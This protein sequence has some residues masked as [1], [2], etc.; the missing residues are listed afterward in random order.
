MESNLQDLY[1]QAKNHK[2]NHKSC[3]GEPYKSFEKL[4]EIVNQFKTEIKI[5][6]VG[7]AVGF[8]T[9]ILQNKINTIDTIELHQEHIDE[10]KV[11]II[12]WG[13]DI[14]KANFL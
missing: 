11:N 3:G 5:L 10:A 8:T 9:F 12:G 2:D 1:N 14:N 13:G 4:Y 6:E 7:T